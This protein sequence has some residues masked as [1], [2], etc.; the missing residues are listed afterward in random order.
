MAKSIPTPKGN[1]L[2][3]S[4]MELQK[5]PLGL[6]E[7]ST[8]AHGDVVRIRFASANA[9]LVNHPDNVEH[10]LTTNASNYVRDG[11][12]QK[13]GRLI[14][15]D[16]L[17]VSEGDFWKKHR[18]IINP[19]FQRQQ[20]DQFAETM[21]DATERLEA[22]W[23]ESLGEGRAVD[24][25]AEMSRLTIDIVGH[26][27]FGADIEGNTDDIMAAED[28][29][30]KDVFTKVRMPFQA[31]AFLP[32]PANRR[33]RKARRTVEGV[34]KTVIEKVRRTPD[35]KT[36][37]AMLVNARDTETGDGLGERHVFDQLTGFVLAGHETSANALTWTLYF[38]AQHPEIERRLLDEY[39]AVLGDRPPTVED[40]PRLVETRNVL[41]ESMRLRPPAWLIPRNAVAGDE[42][43]GYTI[44]GGQLIWVSPWILHRHPAIWSDPTTFDPDRFLPEASKNRHRCAFIPFGLGQ[45][46]CVG[47]GFAM[48]EMQLALPRLVRGFRYRLPE[49]A[50]PIPEPY[51]TLRPRGGMPMIV[52]VRKRASAP[53]RSSSSSSARIPTPAGGYLEAAGHAAALT[54][55]GCPFH[56][57]PS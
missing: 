46:M 50:E 11:A 6:F 16:S 22:R 40:V 55:S 33:L 34:L 4:L 26:A 7:R 54:G 53:K 42:I 13:A 29:A 5:D 20:I 36:L 12:F 27:L 19:I 14:L 10:V 9:V 8:A 56:P 48:L 30:A 32:T 31:P 41:N 18:R 38:L 35:S 52:E 17:V 47:S 51:V 2:L 1:W 44:P 43:G 57:K 21:T 37:T 28:S 24:L 15:G 45:K 25:A 3:G 39:D 23:G 49:G